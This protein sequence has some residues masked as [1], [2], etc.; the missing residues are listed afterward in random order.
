MDNPCLLDELD[1]NH[2]AVFL[3]HVAGLRAIS[4][5]L[6]NELR[7]HNLTPD[8]GEFSDLAAEEIKEELCKTAS[9][10]TAFQNIDPEKNDITY[11]SF[12]LE[13]SRVLKGDPDK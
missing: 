4:K 6:Y 5:L 7:K 8:E 12:H 3:G 13:V 9:R 11:G 10:Y 1:D 2:L